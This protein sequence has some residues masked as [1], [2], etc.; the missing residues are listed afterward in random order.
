MTDTALQAKQVAALAGVH[1]AAICRRKASLPAVLTLEAIAEWATA[2]T[3][4]LSDAECR[5]RVAITSTPED[6]RHA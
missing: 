5:L 6:R 1:P 3:A 2:Q 4:D